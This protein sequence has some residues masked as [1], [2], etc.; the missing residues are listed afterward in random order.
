[1]AI[2]FLSDSKKGC[3]P[4]KPPVK[5]VDPGAL[6]RKLFSIFLAKSS[7]SALFIFVAPGQRVYG[8]DRVLSQTLT[9]YP[10]FLLFQRKEMMLFPVSPFVF[11]D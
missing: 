3:V 8:Y 11:L 5:I 7:L 4:D 1:M 10:A 9:K 6:W 2:A